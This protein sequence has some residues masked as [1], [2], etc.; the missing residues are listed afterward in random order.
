MRLLIFQKSD[1]GDQLKL[2]R[3]RPLNDV[4]TRSVNGFTLNPLM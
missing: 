3:A 4:I 2:W 1:M